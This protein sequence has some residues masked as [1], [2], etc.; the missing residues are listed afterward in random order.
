MKYIKEYLI[1]ILL[2]II[3]LLLIGVYVILGWFYYNE[4]NKEDL[5]IKEE[6]SLIEEDEKEVVPLKMYVDVKGA[7]KNPG[8]YEVTQGAIVNDVIISAGGFNTNAYTK[9]INLSK[10]VIDE[11]VIYIYTQYEYS[12]LSVKEEVKE[13]ICPEVDISSCLNT[14]ASIIKNENSTTTKD[15]KN[16][17]NEVIKE[18]ETTKED[19]SLVNINTASKEELMTLSGIGESKAQKIIDYRN[20]NGNFLS[21]EDIKNVSGISDKTYED[22][23]AYI[24]V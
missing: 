23:K 11:N 17:T 20:E 21:V 10:K 9:N 13:C 6:V 7:V 4:S 19:N 15:N 5:L 2:G 1:E 3:G 14:G 18:E 22:I 8:V 16:N 24:T 12:L